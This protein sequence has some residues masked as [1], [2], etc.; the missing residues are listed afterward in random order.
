MERARSSIILKALSV[1]VVASA[2]VLLGGVSAASAKDITEDQTIT[3]KK[4]QTEQLHIVAPARVTLNLDGRTVKVAGKDAIVIDNGAELTINGEGKVTTTTSGHAPIYNNG[5]LTVN[6]GSYYKNEGKGKTQYYV[7]LNHGEAI[8]NGGSFRISNPNPGSGASLIA[9]GYYSYYNT[10]P[11]TGYV[12]GVGQKFPR[13]TINDGIFTGGVVNVKSD[14]GGFTVINDGTFSG[15]TSTA[16]LQN[17]HYLTINGGTITGKRSIITTLSAGLGSVDAGVTKI[18]N[19]DFN[20]DYLLEGFDKN[21]PLVE[22]VQISGGQFNI[23]AM[24]DPVANFGDVI[25]APA[26]TGGTFDKLDNEIALPDGYGRY[27]IGDGTTVV[28]MIDF[29][30]NKTVTVKLVVGQIHQLNLPELVQKYGIVNQGNIEIAYAN[31]TKIVA[32]N[33]GRTEITVSFSG[34]TRTYEVTVSEKAIPDDKPTEPTKPTTP[35][36]PEQ[37]ATPTEKDDEPGKGGLTKPTLPTAN[38]ELPTVTKPIEDST[39]KITAPS[40]SA[41]NIREV[42]V[43]EASDDQATIALSYLMVGVMFAS[44]LMIVRKYADIRG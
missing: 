12:E 20:A 30:E 42:L 35:T 1:A 9:N 24:V 23:S 17:A 41:R 11:R 14:D 13:L 5:K 4:T 32:A 3:L 7:L 18:T 10:N 37:P 38:K 29:N 21:A 22:P 44:G 16:A 27:D 2:V 40:T 26:I 25:G 15:A 33:P 43:N 31:K 36:K 28:P 6:G 34:V 8:I 39:G 19:G